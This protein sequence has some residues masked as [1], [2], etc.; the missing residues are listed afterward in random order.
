MMIDSGSQFNGMPLDAFLSVGMALAGEWDHNAMRFFP[1][2]GDWTESRFLE[3]YP[4]GTVV[5]GLIAAVSR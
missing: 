2:F 1:D 3:T 5:L 4:A